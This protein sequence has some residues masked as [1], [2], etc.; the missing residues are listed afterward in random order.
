MRRIARV[1]ALALIVSGWMLASPTAAQQMPRYV[2]DQVLVKL[3][4]DVALAVGQNTGRV[5][6]GV[7]SLDQINQTLQVQSFR[8]T[9]PN[10]APPP[11][12]FD[13]NGLRQVYTVQ[14][15]PGSD[16]LAAIAEY[17]KNPAVIYAEPNYIEPLTAITPNDPMYSDQWT[18][19]QTSDVDI[20]T[21]EAWELETGDSSVIIGVM[22]SG[23]LW[24][25]E[26]LMSNI[27]V[28]PGE[29]LD[30]DGEIMDPDDVNGIDD[31]GNGYVD[32]FIGY[33]F[34]VS[35]SGCWAGEDC[36]TAD[37]DPDDFTGHG[38]HVAGI[39]AAVTGNGTGVA[40]I[41]GGLRS[42]RKPGCKIM[43]L[44]MGY[45]ASDGRGYVQMGA[46][47]EAINYAVAN[48]AR[49]INGSWGSSG[50]TIRA[51]AQNAVD[52]GVTFT[53]SAG[54]DGSNDPLDFGSVSQ[55]AEVITVA[56]LNKFN[57][58]D[59]SSNYGT[60]VDISAP[61]GAILSTIGELGV[62]G[63]AEYSGTSMAA[64]TVAGVAAL[65]YSHKPEWTR[66]EVDSVIL[67][68]V[69]DVYAD[70]PNYIGELGTGRVNAYL[71][72]SGMTTAD[73]AVDSQVGQVPFLVNFTDVSPNAPSGPYKYDFGDGDTA[74]TAN[75]SHTYT[76]PGIYSV[77][78]TA[79]GPTG[80]HTRLCPELIVATADTIEYGDIQLP[81]TFQ[82]KGSLP[83]R[84]HNTHPMNQIILP[85][86]LTGTP[87]I[88]IDSLV[89]GP[90]LAGWTKTLV[91][92]NRF[93]GEIAWRLNAPAGSPVPAGDGVIADFWVRSGFGNT[94]G[95]VE[96]VDS[97]TYSAN[98][99]RLTSEWARF[100]AQFIQ[101]SITMFN[102]CSCPFQA[103]FDEDSFLDATD[104]N[105]MIDALFF[106][107]TDPQD[108]GCPTTRA[109]FN[110]DTFTDAVDL[111]SLIDHLF[112]SG[113]PPVDPCAP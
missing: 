82:T 49:V 7:A 64:P 73:F 32:D 62:Q 43:C 2:P 11:L 16:V 69:D 86:K 28:N 51:A 34:I 105:A 60:A 12:G 70:N 1:S 35:Q 100:K 55:V 97:A 36:N 30:G 66:A 91:F 42:S 8:R 61:G 13:R 96:T 99:L 72:L 25:H 68:N 54:N 9:V 110:F 98:D 94:D 39:A 65:V 92:D 24:H 74:A 111:N 27:W 87:N 4:E 101:G 93:S 46:G 106:S 80:P 14:L 56:W 10:A 33:D 31:D 67:L 22:D 53:Y 59:P 5:L 84:L 29:D 78:F 58:K 40:G 50:L 90:R 37:N 79:S 20:D 77:S 44:R 113:P 88:F 83:V 47:A 112:F 102:P 104:M 18:H 26:D 17:Q 3:T 6:T 108:P 45:L 21:D 109:D 63:Y 81:V 41:A 57:K 38:S 76:V 95:Q 15:P 19:F 75:A 103:D 71:S 52:A 48:G 23:V 89:L 85:F 107:G